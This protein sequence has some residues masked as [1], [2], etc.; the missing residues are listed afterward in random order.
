MTATTRHPLCPFLQLIIED[1]RTRA[2]RLSSTTC[3]GGD[4]GIWFLFFQRFTTSWYITKATYSSKTRRQGRVGICLENPLFNTQPKKPRNTSHNFTGK[5]AQG[6]SHNEINVNS[7]SAR[8]A[9][10]FF[11]NNKLSLDWIQNNKNPHSY[12]AA[13]GNQ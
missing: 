3:C 1:G 8:V 9:S 5:R 7:A 10:S 12:Y 6:T 4:G 11:C 13:R 2:D